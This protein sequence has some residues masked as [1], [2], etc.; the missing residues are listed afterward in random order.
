MSFLPL[1]FFRDMGP[2]ALGRRCR[3]RERRAAGQTLGSTM[4]G[5]QDLEISNKF[6]YTMCFNYTSTEAEQGPL[7]AAIVAP[8]RPVTLSLGQEGKT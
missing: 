3:A 7:W 1:R 4:S 5:S 6:N 8:E 2:V